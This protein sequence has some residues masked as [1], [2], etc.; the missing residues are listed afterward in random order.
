VKENQSNEKSLFICNLLLFKELPKIYYISYDVD[1]FNNFSGGFGF[2][3]DRCEGILIKMHIITA[4][5]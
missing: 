3:Y 4:L 5:Q 1:F 2:N